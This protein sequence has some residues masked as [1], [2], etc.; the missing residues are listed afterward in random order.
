[1]GAWLLEPASEQQRLA[2][3]FLDRVKAGRLILPGAHDPLAALLARRA[4]FEAIYLSGAAFSASMGMPDL[5]LLTLSE[6]VERA[7]A[8]VRAT[9]LPLVVDGDTGFGEVLNVVR[10]ARELVE[11]GIAAV[12][13]EDQ[14]MPKKCGHLAGKKL[15]PPSD[16]AAKIYALKKVYPNLVVIARTDAHAI[17]G[18]EGVLHRVALY[19]E[20]GADII[21]PEA[22][23]QREEF[24]V[25]RRH[26][27]VPLLANLT[28]FG[29]TPLFSAEEIF[30]MGYEI[31]LFPVSAL[32]V[33]ARAM[34]EFYTH[35]AQ[36]R[37]SQAFLPRMQT[38]AELYEV[39][40]Y[41][42]YERFDASIVKF[43]EEKGK[44]QSSI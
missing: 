44:I 28:E 11:A 9:G 1:M 15:I 5:G 23:T 8:I 37:S 27:T 34:E 41:E 39:I 16:M 13:L 25:V 6:V 7:R 22:L 14:E 17:E 24:E 35:L 29:K 43:G 40:S 42:E 20:A 12:Q 31:A 36:N 33:A 10:L 2:S 19:E 18:I 30:S 4:G 38:R 3:Q 26:S 32:R 21:F